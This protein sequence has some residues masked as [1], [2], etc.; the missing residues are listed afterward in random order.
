MS[1]VANA[2]AMALKINS[3]PP[4]DN[5]AREIGKGR[6]LAREVIDAVRAGKVPPDTL[7]ASVLIAGQE[8]GDTVIG[9]Y[10]E[11]QD[12]LGQQT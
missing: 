2:M 10:R 7:M 6:K 1:I 11:I 8:G 4:T 5:E 9:V 3:R 12:A